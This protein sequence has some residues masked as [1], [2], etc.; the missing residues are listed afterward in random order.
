MP[1]LITEDERN[2]NIKARVWEYIT[3]ISRLNVVGRL[4]V[5]LYFFFLKT[6]SYPATSGP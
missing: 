6:D 5:Q 1:Y 4:C 3:V 2:T